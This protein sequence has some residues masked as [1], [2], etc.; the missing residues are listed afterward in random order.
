MC[1]LG[2]KVIHVNGGVFVVEEIKIMNYGYGDVK[3]ICLKPYFIDTVNK[4]LTIYVPYDKK[5]ELIRPIMSKQDALQVIEKI[6]NIQPIWYQES[7]VRKE[8]F[9]ELL[10][11]HDIDNI[12][13][14]VK[15]LYT[16]QLELQ[17]N[18]KSLNL[19]DYDYLRKLKKGIEEELAIS[20]NVPIDEIGDIITKCIE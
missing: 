5:D 2:D 9:A 17:E 3:Y 4:T 7:K 11:S 13:V 8:K 16:K 12:C 19:M 20:L 10:N 14:I 6:K 15:S 1:Q 18:N